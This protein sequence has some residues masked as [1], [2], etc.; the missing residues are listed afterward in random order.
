MPES[1]ASLSLSTENKDGTLS[2]KESTNGEEG[3]EL[4]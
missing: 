4:T 3:K 2:A 1:E